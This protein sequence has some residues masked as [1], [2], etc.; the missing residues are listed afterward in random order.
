MEHKLKIIPKYFKEIVDGNK[1]FEVR[2][3]DRNYKIGDT[4]IL[5]EYDPIKKN[6][7]GNYA[8]TTVMYI[9]K[10]KDFPIGIKEGY[11]IMGI[12]L[13]DCVRSFCGSP[14]CYVEYENVS[15]QTVHFKTEKEIMYDEMY[16]RLMQAST[17]GE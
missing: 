6:F 1:N 15:N 16:K 5:K 2:K 13:K 9:L 14:K 12:H 10:D 17:K 7:T 8:K 4:L 3:N 11:C